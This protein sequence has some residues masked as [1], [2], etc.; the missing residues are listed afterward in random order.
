MRP[1]IPLVN[2]WFAS[3]SLLL[4]IESSRCSDQ[5]QQQQQQP[6]KLVCYYTNWAKDRPDPWSYVSI[7]EFDSMIN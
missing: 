3:A 7:P 4:C 6:P 1:Q 2:F 5:E